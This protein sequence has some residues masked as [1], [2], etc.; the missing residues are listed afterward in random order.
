MI[1]FPL[2]EMNLLKKEAFGTSQTALDHVLFK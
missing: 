2:D 1:F